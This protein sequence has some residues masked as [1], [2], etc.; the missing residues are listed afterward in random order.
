MEGLRQA[1]SAQDVCPVCRE[2]LPPGPRKLFYTALLKHVRVERQV[3]RLGRDWDKL[4]RSLQQ[5]IDEVR[6][7]FEQAAAQDEEAAM[8]NLGSIHLYGRGV[9]LSWRK[10]KAWYEKA[11]AKEYAEAQHN[12][13]YMCH[14]GVGGTPVNFTE[15]RGWYEMAGNNGHRQA[16]FLL[17]NM[18][19]SLIHI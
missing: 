17:G 3:K 11:A 7:L 15:A 16:Q 18:Y 13:G 10:A 5:E 1:I 12:L 9:P 4:P 6:E 19:L 2:P 14:F 8:F